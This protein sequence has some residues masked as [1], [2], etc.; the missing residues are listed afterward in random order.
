MKGFHKMQSNE[1]Q[2][3]KLERAQNNYCVKYYFWYFSLIMYS[4]IFGMFTFLL[5]DVPEVT[6]TFSKLSLDKK[7]HKSAKYRI[8]R[9]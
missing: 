3:F 1:Q 9:I 2:A 6:E 5:T 8:Q 7:K 4:V